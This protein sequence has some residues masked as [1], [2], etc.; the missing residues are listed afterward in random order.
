MSEKSTRNNLDYA[1]ESRKGGIVLFFDWIS[2]FTLAILLKNG[3]IR[4]NQNR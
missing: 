1:F 3:T 2:A 4:A